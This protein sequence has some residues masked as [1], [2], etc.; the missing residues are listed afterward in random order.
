MKFFFFF[1]L[2]NSAYVISRSKRSFRRQ[3]ECEINWLWVIKN[4]SG[5]NSELYTVST[6]MCCVSLRQSKVYRGKCNLYGVRTFMYNHTQNTLG[7]YT[8]VWAT[9]RLKLFSVLLHAYSYINIVSKRKTKDC[10]RTQTLNVLTVDN[11]V[12]SI[13]VCPAS[14][15]FGVFLY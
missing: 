6:F 12:S 15:Q 14:Y 9:N 3:R 13:E 1:N 8:S 4:N 5:N 7:V 11:F 10:A 2:Q